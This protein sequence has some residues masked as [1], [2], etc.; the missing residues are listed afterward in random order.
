MMAELF[1]E[2]PQSGLVLWR[3]RHAPAQQIECAVTINFKGDLSLTLRNVPSCKLL[4]AEAH[5]DVRSL[6]R[7]ADDLRLTFVAGGWRIARPPVE[8]EPVDDVVGGRGGE[9]PPL[10]E[11]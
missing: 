3:L 11:S 1:P 4:V 8:D 5:A 10:Q 9:L 2:I 6:V 7:H